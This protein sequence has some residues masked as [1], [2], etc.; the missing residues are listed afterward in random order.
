MGKLTLSADAATS[1][2]ET[3]S[4]ARGRAG[5]PVVDSGER[6]G[7]ASQ[8]PGG[9]SRQAGMPQSVA[10]MLVEFLGLRTGWDGHPLTEPAKQSAADDVVRFLENRPAGV[11]APVP[12]LHTTGDIGLSWRSENSLVNVQFEGDG[13]CYGYGYVREQ[14]GQKRES[15]WDDL[16]VEGDWPPDLGEIAKL[17]KE[18]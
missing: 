10:T 2:S 9:P 6:A 11:P 1:A 16:E 7:D 13:K 8:A 14:H 15:F 5:L 3:P 12:G 17:A 18:R 4:A